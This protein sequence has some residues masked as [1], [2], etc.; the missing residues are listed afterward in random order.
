M[1][2]LEG[3]SQMEVTK[4][5][6]RRTLIGSTAAAGAGL[7]A[8]S[9]LPN[10]SHAARSEAPVE[11]TYWYPWGGDSKTYEENRA[12]TFNASQSEIKATGLYVPP[13]SGVDNGKLLAAIAAGNPPDLVVVNLEPA[14]AI[15]GY[16]GGLVDMTPYLSTLGWSP[17]QMIPGVLP[18]M[19]YGNKIWALPETGNLT[20]FY[21]NKTLFKAAG[22]DPNKPPT[23]LAEVDAYAE[24]LTK[25][26]SKGNF[27]TIGFIPWAW[28][29][30][31]PWIWPWLFGANFTQTVNG[32]VKLTL[33]D[34]H[35]VSALEYLA[36]YGKKYG[37]SKL[38]SAVSSFGAAFS[39]NDPF[40]SGLSAMMVGSDYHT[41]ALRTYNPK[42]DYGVTVLPTAPGG[43]ANATEFSVNI[44]IV[45][46]GSKHPLEAIK[47]A[48]WAGNGSA[49][50][51]N[52]N[53]WHTFCG[54]K[55]AANA[56]KNIW[57]Q[58]GDPVY[59][60]TEF[61]LAKGNVTNGPLLP[62]SNQLN[63]QMAT[64]TQSVYYGKSTALA[65][66]TAVQ[67]TMQP[68]LDKALHQ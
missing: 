39:P 60:V 45:P 24:K 52:E 58:R 25:Y 63:N 13:Q 48:M 19:Q 21:W 62:I 44:Y 47:F 16:Q 50:I 41:E 66:L 3:E 31:D 28:D 49:V 33:T 7:A 10:E 38:Q 6:S 36:S 53:I 64:A 56:P 67:N 8:A 40:I 59:K 29:G 32:K 46:T 1:L 14:A 15:L 20:Y 65:A 43:R 57:Q 27:K 17:S 18:M 22:L 2:L 37:I 35:A 26:D 51:G 54:Y 12:K 9:L 30:A 5:L 11:I 23:T 4:P 55:Q 61:L 34:P 68:L 42:L